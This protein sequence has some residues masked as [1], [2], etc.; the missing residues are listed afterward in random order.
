MTSRDRLSDGVL[1]AF[2]TAGYLALLVAGLGVSSLA[3]DEDVI[4]TRGVGVVPA[5]VAAG[6]AIAVFA[7]L[8]R[9][10]VARERPSYV[11]AAGVALAAG[12]THALVLGAGAL[13]G[14]GDLGVA[15]GAVSEV[16][17]GWVEPVVALTAAVAAGAAIAVRRTGAERPR[18]PWE[19][20]PR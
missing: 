15:L 8:V 19:D 4:R 11:A 13:V 5:Y 1:T 14:A 6:A 2:A 16:L 7:L 17:I 12:A 3:L 20:A 18:W 9:Q 10:T